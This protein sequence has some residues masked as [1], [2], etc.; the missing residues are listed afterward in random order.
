[1]YFYHPDKPVGI[2][3]GKAD[4]L[5]DRLGENAILKFDDVVPD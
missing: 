4:R 5:P 3:P 1:M 2:V